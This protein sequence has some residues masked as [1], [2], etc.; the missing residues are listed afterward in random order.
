MRQTEDLAFKREDQ[1]SELTISKALAELKTIEARI[2]KKEEFVQAYLHRQ[3]FIR[4]PLEQEAGG[5]SGAIQRERQAIRDLRQRTVD[6]RKAI[7]LANSQTILT[8]CGE[9]QTIAEWLVWKRE[10]APGQERFLRELRDRINLVRRDA[11]NKGLSV[12]IDGKTENRNDVI[13]NL[14]ETDLYEEIEKLTTILGELDGEL[15][16]KNATVF[17]EV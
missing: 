16:Q 4:D 8:V 7:S 10:V 6:I 14:N 15:S 5:S 2:E 1:M 11:E 12:A 13:V 9:I 17:I 3:D